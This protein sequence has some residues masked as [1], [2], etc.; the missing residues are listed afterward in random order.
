[1]LK[2]VKSSSRLSVWNRLFAV[3]QQEDAVCWPILTL[4]IRKKQCHQDQ[5]TQI[6]NISC[7]LFLQSVISLLDCEDRFVSN[8]CNKLPNKNKPLTFRQRLQSI[9]F[10][11]KFRYKGSIGIVNLFAKL[12]LWSRNILGMKQS[13]CFR[14]SSLV[15]FSCLFKKP[16][17][18]PTWLIRHSESLSLSLIQHSEEE[19]YPTLKTQSLFFSEKWKCLDSRSWIHKHKKGCWACE[20]EMAIEST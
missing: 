7:Y 15:E 8:T 3:Y 5:Y 6:F 11:K 13:E 18:K 4:H 20:T 17:V 12:K 10:D 14:L 19:L 16:E 9:W 2:V 1:M